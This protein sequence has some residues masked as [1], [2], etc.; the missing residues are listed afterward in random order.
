MLLKIYCGIRDEYLLFL[1]RTADDLSNNNIIPER[2][3]ERFCN[4]DY[5]FNTTKDYKNNTI[6]INDIKSFQVFHVL[7]YIF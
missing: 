7:F 2:K 5:Q 3:R 4:N 6:D 1:A